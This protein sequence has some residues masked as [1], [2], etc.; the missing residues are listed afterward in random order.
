MYVRIATAGNRLSQEDYNLRMFTSEYC[1]IVCGDTPTS[2]SLA[3]SMLYG[4]IPIR[5]GSR[6]RGRCEEP[7][8]PG[9]GWSVA[10]LPHLPF[11]DKIDWESFP[12][13]DEAAFSNNPG[14]VLDQFFSQTDAAKK[15]KFRE[16]MK[17][18]QMGWTYGWGSPVDSMEFG[19]AAKY[20]WDSL[21]AYLLS[22][23][24]TDTILKKKRRLTSS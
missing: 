8:R 4:C 1:L 5:I 24:E 23:T 21:V 12:E 20:A 19:D 15:S 10:D 6:L 16:A 17:Q 11:C 7:C 18:T 2:R 22:S 14:A 3:S 13:V 9:W